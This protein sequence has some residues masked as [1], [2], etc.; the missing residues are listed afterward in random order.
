MFLCVF[1]FVVVDFVW[2]CWFLC[3]FV[4]FC[5][6][7]LILS[8]FVGFCVRLDCFCL[9]LFGCAWRLRDFASVWLCVDWF[10]WRVRGDGGINKQ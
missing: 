1:L 10:A 5:L 4:C 8:G 7:W 6:F 9:F 3:V 2:F